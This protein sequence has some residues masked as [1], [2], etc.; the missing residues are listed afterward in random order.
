MRHLNL[1]GDFVKDLVYTA[2]KLK[3]APTFATTVILTIALGI[4]ASG[5]IFSVINAVLLRPVP[6]RNPDQ[7]VLSEDPVSNADYFDLRDGTHAAFEDLAAIMVFRSIA[8]REDGSAECISKGQVTTNFFHVLNTQI[9]LG[10][11]FTEADGIPKGP[12]PLLFPPP[13][14]SV[15]ILSYDYFQRRYGADPNVIGRRLRG[16]GGTG[17]QIVGVLKPGF[18]MFL[19]ASISSQP[20]VDVWIANDRGYDQ[21]NRGELMLHLIGRLRPTVNGRA[22]AIAD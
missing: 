19:P 7:L 10:R 2:R 8:P 6:Y 1:L 12:M 21:K 14:G 17:P 5:A 20:N 13:E 18:T 11:D 16:T 3:D 22:R 4:G 15:A 9:M